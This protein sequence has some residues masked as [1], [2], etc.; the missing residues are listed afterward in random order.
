MGEN[1]EEGGRCENVEGMGGMR[2]RGEH[3]RNFEN[4]GEGMGGMR[5][6]GKDVSNFENEGE[7][8]GGMGRM[9][10]VGMME[11]YVLEGVREMGAMKCE[12]LTK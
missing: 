12:G 1:G 10:D 11:G 3:V 6:R 9:E 8:M 2:R 7:G 4:V 5:R